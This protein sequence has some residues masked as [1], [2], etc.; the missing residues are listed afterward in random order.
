MSNL[1]TMGAQIVLTDMFTP[2]IHS[3]ERAT[4]NFRESVFSASNAVK[5]LAGSMAVKVGFDWLVKGNADM[6]TYQNTLAIVMGS[7]EKAVETLAWANKFAASTPF[8]IPQ[9]V[10][11]TTRMQSYGLNAQKTLGIVGD[12]A[13]VMGKDLMQAVEA[14]A[15]AQTGEVERLK[16]FGITKGMIQQQAKELGS[17]P[18]NTQGQITDQKAF[19]AALFSLMEKRYKGGMDLQSK[20]FKG[21]LSNV[22]D[23][24]GSAGREL[25]K[26]IFDA[27]KVG[28]GTALDWMNKLQ[29]SGA[30]TAAGNEIAYVGKL[31]GGVF[32]S[33]Y[34][35]AKA[36][37][38]MLSGKL[39]T[40]Y[41]THKP[42]INAVGQLFGKIF[43]DV[44]FAVNT[45]AKPAIEWVRT[46]GLPGLVDILTT[47]GG[48][49]LEVANFFNDNWSTIKPL[50][51]GIAIA[52][53][54]YLGVL[55]T[56]SFATRIAT[57]A[58]RAWNVAMNANPAGLIVTAI[59]LL[60][61]AG[62]LLYQNWDT[63]KAKATELWQGTMTAASQAIDTFKKNLIDFKD[64]AVQKV[65]D[66]FDDLKDTLEE[67]QT[68]IKVTTGI[69]ATLFGP[70][71]IKT[72]I[73]ASIA[74]AQIAGQFIVS[75]VRTGVISTIVAGQIYAGIVTSM[76]ASGVQA[77]KSGALITAQFIAAMIKSSAQAVI[78]GAMI[79][80]S[81]I[82]AMIASG[83]QAVITAGKFTG[84]LV[85]SL[86]AYAA[87][88][89]ATVTA[90]AAQTG[91]LFLNAAQATASGVAW[92]ILRG[93]QLASTAATW[94]MT[95]AQWALNAAMTANPI[96]LVI[97]GI[98][99]LVGAGILL[100][101]N[102]DTVKEKASDLW[103]TIENAFKT[104]VNGAIDLINALI[105]QIRKIPGVDIPLIA[106]VEMSKTTSQQIAAA[107]SAGYTDN[108]AVNGK[109]K[110]GLNYVPF[111]G[112]TAELH[113]GESVLTREEAETWRALTKHGTG[114]YRDGVTNIGYNQVAEL[115]KGEAILPKSQMLQWVQMGRQPS[116]VS[117]AAA[118]TT[119]AAAVGPIKSLSP[120]AK[121]EKLSTKP[122]VKSA[123]LNGETAMS[124][125]GRKWWDKI[126]NG[127][128]S[129]Q[130]DSLTEAMGA[131]G[132][133][134]T[135]AFKAIQSAYKR[136]INRVDVTDFAN[137]GAY[138]DE[139]QAIRGLGHES[140]NMSNALS[141]FSGI[142]KVVGPVG[143][144]LNVLNIMTADDKL[145]AIVTTIGGV[146]GG[147][148]G[149]AIAG[150]GIGALAGMGVLSAPLALVGGIVGSV[151][152]AIAGQYEAGKLYN[153]VKESQQVNGS[154]ANGLGYVPFDG[155]V[156][157]LH[158]G[159]MVLTAK[160][161]QIMR[162]GIGL[163]GL[164]RSPGLPGM[165]GA[166][167]V[168]GL[169]GMSK[170]LPGTGFSDT[171]R[172]LAASDVRNIDSVPPAKEPS[173]K[174]TIGKLFDSLT[175]HGTKDMDEEKLANVIID[176]LHDKLTGASDI[177]GSA[178]M[179]VLL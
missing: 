105:T 109:H 17:N 129:Q 158:K 143:A 136:N 37:I 169:P 33:S 55:K 92:A 153:M 94:A 86:V 110:N 2:R 19:N 26:P 157:A 107:K 113:K 134:K 178:D 141:K 21:M 58:Q 67:H 15:D 101:K 72:G 43:N 174:I 108:W 133:S 27:M 112:Y 59:G 159:E 66:I 3:A 63:V 80:G 175:V 148:A 40:F 16:E 167:G 54:I 140:K 49:V 18:I 51:E 170:W 114:F 61:G 46:V 52:W 154:H 171:G 83:A 165:S 25:G 115:H 139:V 179:G 64:N 13:S 12:M 74:G 95:A 122:N 6:E 65:K 71:L 124:N 20:T 106:H 149:G 85:V 132:T 116:S 4:Q 28:L 156:A 79:T 50:I 39:I 23:F 103:V 7:Q 142:N 152:G 123:A 60:I 135:F 162:Q 57:A 147:A 96:G 42:Q 125:A 87:Q 35:V 44:Q 98:G 104:G 36:N 173:R 102:W 99:L 118:A 68:A 30:I 111:D 93:I 24:I 32:Y 130:A 146:V 128:T 31:V 97:V 73:Q 78:S 160:E 137:L 131:M 29:G 62:I 91:A 82:A 176:K 88:G 144:A 1:F 172:K 168:T 76:I 155:Y 81:F 5:A 77:I 177:L 163:P 126:V 75:V 9:I 53:G 166:A 47:V 89:W 100:Y 69:L 120:A 14:V 151:G 138:I 164:S 90:I 56:I 10:E 48:G 11:A 45:Y 34:V 121:A 119:E 127:L 41:N 70:A 38:D 84:S 8:E 22:Q 145:E 150:A 161:A 117:P